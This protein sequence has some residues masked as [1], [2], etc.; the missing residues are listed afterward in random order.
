M[1]IADVLAKRGRQAF[2]HDGDGAYTIKFVFCVIL[3]IFHS[4]S[5]SFISACF[6]VFDF[7]FQF[8]TQHSFMYV[9]MVVHNM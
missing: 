5:L 2:L 9:E 4:H 3:L 6:T 8:L 1:F 7:M